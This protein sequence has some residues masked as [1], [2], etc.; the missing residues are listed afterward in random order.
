MR[1]LH[2]VCVTTSLDGADLWQTE[3]RSSDWNIGNA[4]PDELDSMQLTKIR[5]RQSAGAAT[6]T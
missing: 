1:I 6:G 4:A 2:Q 5:G 3:R